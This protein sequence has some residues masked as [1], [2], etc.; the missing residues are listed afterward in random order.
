MNCSIS[1]NELTVLQNGAIISQGPIN[2]YTL[3]KVIQLMVPASNGNGNGEW[4][5]T[6]A[7]SSSG[8]DDESSPKEGSDYILEVNNLSGRGSF[9]VSLNL[10]CGEILGVTG[11][12]GSGRTEFAES[13][14]GIRKAFDGCITLEGKKFIPFKSSR[15][16]STGSRLSARRPSSSWMFSRRHGKRKYIL[17]G[18]PSSF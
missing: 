18:A 14:A 5:N 10:R 7:A 16:D 3:K 2:H 6:C 8:T 15:L 12:V 13:V 11:V 1:S 17:V 4:E 9:N